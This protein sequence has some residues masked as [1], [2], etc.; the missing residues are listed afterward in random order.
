MISITIIIII[1]IIIREA[2]R[3]YQERLT[4]AEINRVKT[5]AERVR[6]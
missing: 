3:R 4:N 2:L 1:I 5:V 6:V